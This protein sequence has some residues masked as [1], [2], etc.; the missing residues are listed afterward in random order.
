MG[1]HEKEKRKAF[2]KRR[3]MTQKKKNKFSKDTSETKNN[4]NN[5]HEIQNLD[6]KEECTSTFSSS[7]NDSHATEKSPFHISSES[8]YSAKQPTMKPKEF[9]WERAESTDPLLVRWQEFK[10]LKTRLNR[11]KNLKF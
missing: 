10:M 3:K 2:A 8:G 9:S 1:R 11:I 5:S 6:E 7:S 4:C